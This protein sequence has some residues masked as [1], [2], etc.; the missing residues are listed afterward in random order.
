MLAGEAACQDAA[1]LRHIER[2]ECPQHGDVQEMVAAFGNLR[3]YAVYF[4]AEDEQGGGMQAG[5]EGVEA[6]FAE[7]GPVDEESRVPCLVQRPG[8]V[9]DL[10]DRK[11]FQ[12]S[13]CGA[14]RPPER[15]RCGGV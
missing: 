6:A 3:A 15:C 13:G 2:I 8:D 14:P 4:I 12:R 10:G 5:G 1:R 7:R 11:A 9:H